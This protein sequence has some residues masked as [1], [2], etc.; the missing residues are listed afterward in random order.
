MA[1]VKM[2]DLLEAGVHFGARSSSWN[3]KMAPY[4]HG[5]RSKIHIVDLKQTM[6]G[7]IRACALLKK[8]TSEGKQ[9]VFVGTKRQAQ[10]IVRTEAARANQHF[11]AQ[12]WLGGTLTNLDTIRK[13]VKRLIEL[14][15]LE[16]GGHLQ[17]F[18]KKMIS[19]IQREKRKISRNFEGIRNMK[20]LP[21][22]MV[23]V[24]P[25]EERIAL[26]EAIKLG[27]PTIALVDTDCDPE[28]VDVVIPGNDDS[29]RSIQT[30]VGA[31][32]DACAE[33]SGY[34]AESAAIAARAA[35]GPATDIGA[36]TG[37]VSF[38]GD[39]DE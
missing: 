16:T 14:E 3:P 6:R 21:A 22:A 5:K 34:S 18:S 30:I 31:M 28:P 24:D 27:I 38:G 32:A 11:V 8:L 20:S 33:G 4:I 9:V 10:D 7:L 23:I 17:E 19:S 37:A 15:E 13:R 12:R 29:L 25:K 2:Q 35:E 1:S 26:A 36:D 39:S